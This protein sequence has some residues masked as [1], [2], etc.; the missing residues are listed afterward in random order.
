MLHE[1]KG[2]IGDTAIGVIA[3]LVMIWWSGRFGDKLEEVDI[4]NDVL[5]IYIDD[6]NGVYKSVRA[7]T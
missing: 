4:I 5:K 1:N 3:L 2:C 7:G 6:I